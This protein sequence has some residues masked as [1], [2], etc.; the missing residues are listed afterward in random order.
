MPEPD[1]IVTDGNGRARR[2]HSRAGWVGLAAL[3]DREVG[4]GKPL[5]QCG[6]H[7]L[8]APVEEIVD[9][10]RRHL[11][12]HLAVGMAAHAIGDQRQDPERGLRTARFR[13]AI[14]DAVLVRGS[15]KAR[16]AQHGPPHAQTR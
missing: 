9:S 1:L 5:D 16:V 15:R 10:L 13:N 8:A 7:G 2:S 14:D 11:A 4:S 12:R 3:V 6:W